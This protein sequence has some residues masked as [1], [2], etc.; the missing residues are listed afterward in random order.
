MT[1]GGGQ[2]GAE[3]VEDARRQAQYGDAEPTAVVQEVLGSAVHERLVPEGEFTAGCHRRADLFER[4]VECDRGEEEPGVGRGEAVPVDGAPYVI[5]QCGLLD[6]NALG[7][8]GRPGG[9]GD[10]RGGR[11]APDESFVQR[12]SWL[13][14]T[15]RSRLRDQRDRAAV[16]DDELLARGRQVR[17]QQGEGRADLADRSHRDDGLEADR[18]VDDHHGFGHDAERAQL[19]GQRV[20]G[21]G[22][23]TVAQR[24]LSAGQGG[25]VGPVGRMGGDRGVQRGAGARGHQAFTFRGRGVTRVLGAVGRIARAARAATAATTAPVIQAASR[26]ELTASANHAVAWPEP[27]ASSS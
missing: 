24:G 20:R 6:D 15:R 16:V 2:F 18:Q 23:V 12:R 26:P 22:E 13:R 4:K 25:F 7:D 5:L 19:R 10:V 21:C 9:V 27:W 11:G 3:P 14:A 1:G 8:A 17:F